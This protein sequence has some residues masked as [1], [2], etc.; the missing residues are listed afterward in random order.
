MPDRDHDGISRASPGEVADNPDDI[1]AL[2]ATDEDDDPY[3]FLIQWDDD[4]W[5]F[6]H[7]PHYVNPME[8]L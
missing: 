5:I 3:G 1:T 8:K 6:A 2:K 4:E 7:S